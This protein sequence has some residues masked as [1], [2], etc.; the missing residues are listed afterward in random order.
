MITFRIFHSITVGKYNNIVKFGNL[1]V[2]GVKCFPKKNLEN[3]FTN[4]NIATY[5]Y[6]TVQLNDLC[7]VLGEMWWSLKVSIK[8]LPSP[9]PIR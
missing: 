1:D 2:D 3:R 5:F 4:Y 7:G 9:A 6:K 8:L